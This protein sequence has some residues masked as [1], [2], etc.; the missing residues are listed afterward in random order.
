MRKFRERLFSFSNYGIAGVFTAL[1]ILS[2]LGKN[3]IEGSDDDIGMYVIGCL[4]PLF[5][6]TWGATKAIGKPKDKK[7]IIIYS[8]ADFFCVLALCLPALSNIVLEGDYPGFAVVAMLVHI[9]MGVLWYKKSVKQTAKAQ[10]LVVWN[11]A[12]AAILLYLAGGVIT[13][14]GNVFSNIF[15]ALTLGYWH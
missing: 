3:G 10:T 7:G 9:T 4:V 2:I 12:T 5:I 13:G 8:V 1:V 11:I 6:K 15:A 14:S